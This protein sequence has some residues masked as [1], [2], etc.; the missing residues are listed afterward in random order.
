MIKLKTQ[1]ILDSLHNTFL[2][3][4]IP[5]IKIGDNVRIGFKI[6]EGNKER[7]QFYEGIVIAKK[8]RQLILLLQFEKYYKELELNEFF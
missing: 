2:K 7:I 4:N 8:I 5:D 6:F 1:Q 3:K